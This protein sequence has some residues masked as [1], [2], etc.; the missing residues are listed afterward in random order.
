[1]TGFDLLLQGGTVIDG[2]GAPARRA[3]VGVLGDRILAVGDLGAVDP[4]EVGRVIDV[5]GRVVAPGFVDPHGH[6][7]GSVLVDAGLDSH[8][9]QGFTTQLSG[10]CG[11]TLAPITSAGRELVEL[12]LRPH[13]LTARWST[14]LEYLDE[15]ERQALGIN[16]AFLVGHGTVRGSVLGPDARP[17]TADELKAMV[18]EVD[19]AMDAGA[20]GLSSGLIYAPGL[21]A[22]LVELQTLAGAAARHGGLYATHMRNEAGGLF[23]ALAEAVATIRGAGDGARLQVSHLKCGARGVWGRGA[24]AVEVLER[25]RA[26]GLDVAADQYPYTAA[27]TTLTT[28]LPPALLGLGVDACVAALADLEVRALVKA[29][30]DRGTSGW[31]DIARDPGWGSIRISYAASHP[32]WSGRTL[33]ELSDVVGLHP[34]DVAFEALMD[35][36]LDVS[37]VIDCMSEDDVEAIMAVP[38]ISVCTD[39][40]GRRPGH[41]ILDAGKPHPRTYGSTARVLGTYVRDRGIVPLEVAIAKLTS[42]PAARVGLRDRGAVREGAVADLVVFDP[43]TI[44]DAATYVEPARHPVG[45]DLV[46]VNGGLAVEDGRETGVRT[47]RLLRRGA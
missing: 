22:D 6:S 12:A 43:A 36:R 40:E 26:D 47:G 30:I 23:D 16:V 27:A 8:L 9:S 46:I 3:D 15:V 44:A 38:W 37:I 42:V 31:E 4:A 28:I 45:M 17:P 7:D 35:D 41:P 18:R 19:A 34:A 20:I 13:G 32:D 2:T 39:A 21:H 10:N 25:A 33:T 14:F 5:V 1:V 24:E 11:E 29:E